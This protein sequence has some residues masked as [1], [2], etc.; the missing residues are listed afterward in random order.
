MVYY[1]ND[2]ALG[3]HNTL[4]DPEEENKRIVD[5]SRNVSANREVSLIVSRTLVSL[6]RKSGRLG[7]SL[8]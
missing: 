8:G 3:Y 1:A 5:L 6:P 4:E 7:F 2:R